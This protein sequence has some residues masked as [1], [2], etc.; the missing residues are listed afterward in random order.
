MMMQGPLTCAYCH[1]SDGHGGTVTFMMQSYDVPNI[2]W[3]ALT[4]PDMDHPP[5]TAETLKLAITDGVDPAGSPLE[6]PMP[7][8]IMLPEDLNDLVAFIM[9]LK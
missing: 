3:P 9:T 1:G 2:T 8:W 6:Y 7:R 5:Y 4:A